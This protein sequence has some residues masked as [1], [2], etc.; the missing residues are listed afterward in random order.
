[1]DLSAFPLPHAWTIA[2]WIVAVPALAAAFLAVRWRRVGEGAAARVWPAAVAAIV[3]LWTIRASIDSHLAFHLS[4]IAALTLACGIPL[5]LVGGAVVVGVSIALGDASWTSAAATW[6]AGVALPALVVSAVR[7]AAAA[8]LPRNLF[9]FIFVVAYFGAAA[10]YVATGAV[11]T[12]LAV[13]LDDI[14]AS[15]AFGD[16]LIV[17]GTLAFGEAL[18]TGML[19]ALGVVYRP[20]WIVAFDP[21]RHGMTP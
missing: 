16:W 5:A 21:G 4:G 1:M 15:Q 10:A 6:L 3:G 17:L 18:L 11:G 7:L 8:L 2:A 13:A 12:A 9:V 19:I 20:H 14:P